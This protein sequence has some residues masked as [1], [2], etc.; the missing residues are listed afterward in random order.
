M[1]RPSR[2]LGLLAGVGLAFAMTSSV[3]ALSPQRGQIIVT[4]SRGTFTCGHTYWVRAT[5]FDQF[6]GR[7]AG[8]RVHWDFKRTPARGRDT[9]D[10][11]TSK[12][13][14]SGVARTK[15]TFVCVAGDR[16]IRARW[17]GLTGTAVIHVRIP[18]HHHSTTTSSSATGAV[19]GVTSISG[20][21]SLPSTSTVA[22]VA[23][24]EP[25]D[26]SVPVIPALVGVL[27]G[28]AIFLRRLAVS[29]R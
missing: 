20:A 19:L 24:T 2:L 4:P 22:P 15:V 29:R 1:K 25:K 26:S 18:R 9:I 6:G 13:N 12:T 16:K 28:M 14:S 3:F 8:A 27:T 23:S 7:V 5:V 10:P 17:H 21:G 11:L